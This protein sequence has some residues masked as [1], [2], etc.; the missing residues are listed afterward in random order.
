VSTLGTLRPQRLAGLVLAALAIVGLG[1]ITCA[2][3]HVRPFDAS[4]EFSSLVGVLLIAPF[5]WHV[6]A[7]RY[8]LAR[9][10]L[11]FT[12]GLALAIGLGPLVA[13]RYATPGIRRLQL[14]LAVAY[15]A[16]LAN[17]EVRAGDDTAAVAGLRRHLE[18]M[19]TIREQLAVEGGAAK[20][21]AVLDPDHGCRALSEIAAL[22]PAT[23]A[24]ARDAIVA[25][26]MERC[27]GPL[28]DAQSVLSVGSRLLGFDRE[29]E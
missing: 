11:V 9:S 13:F 2:L 14:M 5:G 26:V 28:K 21:A 3:A 27:D 7:S 15:S 12:H 25:E 4:L 19:A 20:D 16:E 22:T 29:S 24:G 10:R 18:R 17:F 6:L 23:E 8:R 1:I